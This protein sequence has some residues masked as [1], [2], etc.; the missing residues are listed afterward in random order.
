MIDIL[1]GS[2]N[3]EKYIG[4]QIASIV[5]QTYTDWTLYVHDDG[6]TDGT[7]GIIKKWCAQDSRIHFID[8][9]LVFHNPAENFLHL[10]KFSTAD[11]ICFS[12]QD[13]YWFEYKL[14][15]M[16]S[17]FNK[18]STKPELLLCGCYLWNT[19]RKTVAPQFS[20]N[21]A[22]SLEEFLFLNGGLQGCA[23]MFNGILKKCITGK[24]FE[25]VYMHD[26][27]TALAAFTFGNVEYLDEKLFLYRQHESN[28][29]VHLQESKLSYLKTISG[30]KAVPVVFEPV[31]EAVSSF[32]TVFQDE[33]SEEQKSVFKKY[34]SYPKMNCISRFISLL[35][36]RFS[37]GHNGHFKLIAKLLLRKYKELPHE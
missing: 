30:N 15:E 33:F 37:L 17:H 13:D 25:N 2:Y 1:L 9:G 5:H 31:Y 27:V 3:G 34:L 28:V 20:C 23:S 10:L 32:F 24:S 4:T 7:C 36:S 16:L 21:K 19:E 14:D 35:F 29:S 6:S 8:D 26:Y 22:Y 12:D 11:C 18:K